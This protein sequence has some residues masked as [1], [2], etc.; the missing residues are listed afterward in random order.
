MLSRLCYRALA[1]GLT[2]LTGLTLSLV[3]AVVPIAAQSTGCPIADD[4]TVSRALGVPESGKVDV[5][6][7]AV[8]SC[9]FSGGSTSSPAFGVSQEI[10]AFGA[11]EGG[12]AA[13][14]ARYIPGLPDAARAEIDALGQAGL[15]VTLPDS[16][17]EAVGGLG[18]SALWVRSQLVPGFYKDSLLVQRGG[19]AFAFDVDDSP[20]ARAS[21]TTLAQA[22]LALPA[23]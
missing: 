2:A 7:D 12:A 3:V 17:F 5:T 1:S 4:G 22:V 18:D 11:G 19:D 23:P 14:A 6:M 20:T 21:L 10:G 15:S 9:T 8:T 13:L 16:E